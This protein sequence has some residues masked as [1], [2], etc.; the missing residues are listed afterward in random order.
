M[1][2]L[3]AGRQPL[4]L[5]RVLCYEDGMFAG[6]FD[7]QRGQSLIDLDAGSRNALTKRQR[8]ERTLR[9]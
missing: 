5:E 3:A 1:L 2:M 7:T 9:Q 4:I 8:L 6:M